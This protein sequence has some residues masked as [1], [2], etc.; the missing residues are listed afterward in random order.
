MISDYLFDQSIGTLSN[1]DR[2]FIIE[3]LRAYSW[4]TGVVIQYPRLRTFENVLGFFGLWKIGRFQA[5][6]AE[7]GETVLKRRAGEFRHVQNSKNIALD[8]EI[9]D[10]ELW[11]EAFFL[12]WAG[13][14][15]IIN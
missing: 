6:S 10:E 12:I 13:I 11:A 9:T 7:Y 2:M 8:Q 3:T 1:P 14:A 5:W 15:L 4:R